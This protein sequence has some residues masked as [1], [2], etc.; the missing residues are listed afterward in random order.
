M[1]ETLLQIITNG[2]QSILGDTVKT[3]LMLPIGYVIRRI[4]RT[5]TDP[6]IRSLHRHPTD[7]ERRRI[8]IILDILALIAILAVGIAAGWVTR[9]IHSEPTCVVPR[10]ERGAGRAVMRGIR[11]ARSHPLQVVSVGALVCALDFRNAL[12]HIDKADF[13]WGSVVRLG[14]WVGRGVRGTI[15]R[16]LLMWRAAGA[17]K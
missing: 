9:A 16:R 15:G 2:A 10:V 8:H 7:T 3:A 14:R 17:M 4:A 6:L 5:Q 1:L 11:W 12:V 13:V